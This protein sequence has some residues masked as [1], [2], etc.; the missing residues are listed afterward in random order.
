MIIKQSLLLAAA[1]L[2]PLL[3]KAAAPPGPAIELLG[4]GVQIYA[5]TVTPEGAAWKLKAPEATLRDQSGRIAGRHFAGP[6]WQAN[7]GSTVVGSPVVVSPSADPGSIPWL[8]LSA[9]QHTGAGLFAAV[10]YIT[11]TRTVGGTAPGS[12]CDSTDQGAEAKVPYSAVYTFFTA[13][14]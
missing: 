12:G 8:V 10:A 13:A 4:E 3:A 1:T 7:D 14:P 5:C 6:A 9:T 11:R 2:F